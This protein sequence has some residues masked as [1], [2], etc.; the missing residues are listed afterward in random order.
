M[1]LNFTNIYETSFDSQAKL[2]YERRGMRL[3]GTCRMATQV[4]GKEHKFPVYGNPQDAASKAQYESFATA[5]KGG[6]KGFVTAP[7]TTNFWHDWVDEDD[8]TS[9]TVDDVANSSLEAIN[10]VG[11]KSDDKIV[12]AL[13]AAATNV[14]AVAATGLTK[15]K[16]VKGV[17]LLNKNNVPMDDRFALVD[18]EQWSNLLDIEQFA[19]Q[20]YIGSDN[21]PWL[22]SANARIWLGVTWI[23]F[24]GLPLSTKDRSCFMYHRSAIGYANSIPL[25]TSVDMIDDRDAWLIK[26]KCRDGSIILDDNGVVKIVCLE[27]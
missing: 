7:L 8:M 23:L 10:T 13:S 5:G 25:K 26:A 11:K 20:D 3:P 21:L 12:T 6:T 27:A 1:S 4:V 15:A 17:E 2:A 24:P 16:C 19:S 9:S 14:V 22:T 18:A